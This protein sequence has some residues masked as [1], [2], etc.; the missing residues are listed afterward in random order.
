MYKNFQ[1][2]FQNI[3]NNLQLKT[4]VRQS[5]KLIDN[6]A[7]ASIRGRFIYLELK[8][9]E[10]KKTVYK[11]PSIWLRD[12]CQCAECF[13]TVSHSRIMNWQTMNHNIAPKSVSLDEQLKIIWNDEHSSQFD[14]NWL[15]A[16]NFSE[17]NQES[18]LNEIYRP[19]PRFW[20]KVE[21]NKIVESFEFND[22]LRT[23]DGLRAWLH[24]LSVNGVAMINDAPSTEDTCRRI[25]DQ[26]GFIKKTHYGEEFIVRAKEGTNNVAY[27]SAPLQIHTDLPYYEYKPGVNLLHCLVQSSSP[28]AFNLLVDGFYVANRM[29]REYPDFYRILTETIVNWSDYG[30]ED[31]FE[32]RKV[33]RAPVIW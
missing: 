20:S 14:L 2:I 7:S 29:R 22:I 24:S 18:Y 13:H 31:G 6:N 5:F 19:K 21:F 26:I 8:N 9:M 12:N 15:K 17:E 4:I 23:K 3:K 16:R 30:Q 1:Q 33:Y 28:G 27:L 32:F 11:F 25:A 10:A